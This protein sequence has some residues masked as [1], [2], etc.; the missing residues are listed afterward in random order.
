MECLPKLQ[1]YF[2][3]N[4]SKYFIRKFSTSL[5]RRL[6]QELFKHSSS[7]FS[8]SLARSMSRN[9]LQWHLERKKM[10]P[11]EIFSSFVFFFQKHHQHLPK[12]K[13]N[14]EFYKDISVNSVRIF[15]SVF[16][17]F[18]TKNHPKN[19]SWDYPRHTSILQ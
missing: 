7:K 9:F 3:T 6:L 4:S 12:K 2:S 14:P 13:S 5:L 10:I 8:W 18:L 15:F 16:L 11:P 1:K 19:S 17:E